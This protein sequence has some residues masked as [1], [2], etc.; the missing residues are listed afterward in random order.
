VLHPRYKLAYFQQEHWPKKWLDS[1]RHIIRETYDENYAPLINNSSP[2]VDDSDDDNLFADVHNF[3]RS[4]FEDVLDAYLN[5]PTSDDDPIKF[6][7]SRLDSPGARITAQGALAIM[8]LEFCSAPAASTDVERLFSHGGCIVTK[9]RH[10]L[11]YSTL[12]CLMVLR[13]W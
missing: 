1:A 11:S 5:A 6:W 13:S 4:T 7:T 3:G 2:A 8:G 9:R 10:N 12:R